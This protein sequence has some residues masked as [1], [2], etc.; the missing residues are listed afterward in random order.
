MKKSDRLNILA[1]IAG[2]SDDKLEKEYYHSIADACSYSENMYDRGFA[3]EDCIEEDKRAKFAS[4]RCDLLEEMC[5]KRGIGL[6]E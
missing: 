3:I 6:F 4:E 2:W 1:E 5:V